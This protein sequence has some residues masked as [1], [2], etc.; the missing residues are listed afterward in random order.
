MET[1]TISDKD[2]KYR[3]KLSYLPLHETA[4]L[5]IKYQW[6]CF[7]RIRPCELLFA[8]WEKKPHLSPNL[9]AC[10][11]FHNKISM[12]CQ[13]TV[14]AEKE[15]KKRGEILCQFIKFARILV[16][17]QNYDMAFAM[18]YGLTMKPIERLI[19]DWA[20]VSKKEEAQLESVKALLSFERN[21][22]KYRTLLKQIKAP[23]IPLFSVHQKEVFSTDDVQDTYIKDPKT[24][25]KKINFGKL[26]LIAESI[27]EFL[28]FQKDGY[29][30]PPA[31]VPEVAIG[32]VARMPIEEYKNHFF[33][34]SYAIMEPD[35]LKAK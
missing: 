15:S 34:L 31:E 18:A 17:Q 22:H 7:K 11:S 1:P 4:F 3:W 21:Y 33:D 16:E 35:Y 6:C 10:A 23:A 8:N 20:Y 9:L 29:F 5:L 25:E 30:F 19:D 32:L 26:S 28:R 2:E 14:L 13:A 12:F 24:G 27:R